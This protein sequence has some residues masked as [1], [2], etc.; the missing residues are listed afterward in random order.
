MVATASS[1]WDAQQSVVILA[2]PRHVS[3]D[4]I[5]PLQAFCAEVW[6]R[7]LTIHPG[8][9]VQACFPPDLPELHGAV[10]ARPII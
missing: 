2:Y 8:P 5:G 6:R 4:P 10:A 7:G 1:K 9:M 3:S